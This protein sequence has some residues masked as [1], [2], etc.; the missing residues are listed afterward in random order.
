MD[1]PA[2]NVGSSTLAV[3]PVAKK[4][5]QF[6]GVCNLNE[7]TQ[8]R[9]GWY[10]R[11]KPGNMGDR[12]Q[13]R[14]QADFVKYCTAWDLKQASPIYA[15]RILGQYGKENCAK[16]NGIS[17]IDLEELAAKKEILCSR[18]FGIRVADLT[19]LEEA[20]SLSVVPQRNCS[21]NNLCRKINGIHPY[22]PIQ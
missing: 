20:V 22:Q 21:A 4:N 8:Y 15:K 10:K 1:R 18:S 2:I 11:I 12:T 17:C 5:P 13:A 16:L 19:S 9:D 3:Q 6:N 7:M 14:T